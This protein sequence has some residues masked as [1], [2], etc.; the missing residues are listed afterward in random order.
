MTNLR[1]NIY[2]IANAIKDTNL[3]NVVIDIGSLLEDKMNADYSNEMYQHALNNFIAK[4]S[5]RSSYWIPHDGGVVYE[6]ANCHDSA[7]NI[8]PYCKRCG[9]IMRGV[10]DEN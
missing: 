8:Y 7:G 9:C 2:E 6:C 10:N 5:E 3:Q 4:Y 1:I